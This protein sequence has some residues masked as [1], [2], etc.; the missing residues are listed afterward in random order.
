M[1]IV[2]TGSL[3]VDRIMN[4][5]GTF[6]EHILPDKIHVL[7]VSF[8]IESLEERRGGT[9][10]NIAYS[11]ALVGQ[12]PLLVASGGSDMSG[13]R[14]ALEEIGVDVGGVELHDGVKTASAYIITDMDNN[15]IT[16]F[17]M[18]AMAIETSASAADWGD[19]AVVVLSPGNKV[20][21]LRYAAEGAAAGQKVVFDPGQTLPFLEPTEIKT[22][23]ANAS[24]LI[25]NDYELEMILKRC[26]MTKEEVRAQVDVQVVTRGK[27]GS[28]I[29]T[30]DGIVDVPVC[31]VSEAV[32]PTGAGDAYR[33]GL[34]AGIVNGL[35]WAQ[36]GR[37]GATL[38][39]YAVE[40]KGTQ[41]HVFTPEEVA[42]RYQD[43]FGDT[44][45]L[46]IS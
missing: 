10:G 32:D 45:P 5:P 12:K 34:L 15:Q 17:H 19:D 26:E 14:D 37:V 24:M 36:C 41:E 40:K 31:P 16:G 35:D 8:N 42:K 13:Y 3:A 9:A 18:G 20:D 43:A 29:Y 23:L 46:S 30:E 11:L 7:N 33:S 44:F 21:M 27:E 39:A 38:A 2:L 28:T 6:G 22:L 25:T 4:F 1:N